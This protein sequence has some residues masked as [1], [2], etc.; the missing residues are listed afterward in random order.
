MN[1]APQLQHNEDGRSSEAACFQIAEHLPVVVWA[2]VPDWSAI[3]YVNPAFEKIW[4]MPRSNLQLNPRAWVK[5][6]HADD[7]DKLSR[8]AAR[9][10]K[11]E[12]FSVE[13]RIRRPNGNI[14]WILDRGIPVRDD[15]GQLCRTVRISE[16]ITERK[17]S[18][19]RMRLA[20]QEKL[21]LLKETHHRVKNNLQIISSL[22]NLQAGRISD[23]AALRCIQE[24]QDR[25]GAIA[26]V[27]EKLA[28][29]RGSTSDLDFAEYA[30]ELG[31]NLQATWGGKEKGSSSLQL[32]LS[33]VSLPVNVAIPLGL[34][35]NELVA[36]CYKHAF[37]GGQPGEIAVELRLDGGRQCTLCVRDNGVGFSPQTVYS[38]GLK[39]VE[40]LARQLR[41]TLQIQSGQGTQV[42]VT[43]PMRKG[44]A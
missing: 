19:S 16:D 40:R 8:A 12:P 33:P 7:L 26:L 20:I 10:E 37:P 15:A 41:A 42:I 18:E 28:H 22:L 31:R 44:A 39:L 36:N 29:T 11:G 2:F 3:L 13:Y 27:H 32:L 35:L 6:V 21:A 5:S 17:R 25:I 4:G 23:Q 43:F 30:R 1:A 9:S 38:L 24:S 34:I 14:R